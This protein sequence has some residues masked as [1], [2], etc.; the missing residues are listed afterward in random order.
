MR[1]HRARAA[2]ARRRSSRPGP[3][4]TR[5]GRGRR[6]PRRSRGRSRGPARSRGAAPPPRTNGSK[7]RSCS[8]GAMPGPR[9]TTRTSSRPPLTRARTETGSPPE[10]RAA[11]SS[12]FANARSSCAGVGE[13][14]RQVAVDGELH[15]APPGRPADVDRLAQHLLDRAPVAA[16]LGRARLQPRELEQLVD[17]AREPRA[18]GSHAGRELA[19]L[20]VAR[21]RRGERLGRRDDRRQRRAQVV[22]DRA[23]HGGLDLVRAAQRARLDDL[24]RERVARERR[25]RAA[26]RAPGARRRPPRRAAS[27]GRAACR[28][29]RRRA[30]AGA[31]PSARRRRPPRARAGTTAGRRRARS[32]ARPARARRRGR[33][34]RAARGPARPRGRP[35]GPRRTRLRARAPRAPR[36]GSTRPPRRRGRRRSATRFSPSAI[37]KRPV[38]GMWKKLNASALATLVREPEQRAP[39]DRDEQHAEQ[40]DDAERD[41]LRD[42]AE[43]IQQQRLGGDERGRRDQPRQERG[44]PCG[45]QAA[46]HGTE[47]R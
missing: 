7:I 42:L 17:Q 23:Q 11:F 29:A 30:R 47:P 31:P 24:A 38:G 37:V 6:W 16:R 27:W 3:A 41:G 12:R 9:S 5:R 21:G 40:V 35:R 28:G 19:P 25:R 1:R 22:R 45:Q 20:L 18:L 13:D 33:A 43:R 26:P 36:R 44:R 14:Q 2:A 15:A 46:E 34:R 10:W 4:A 8:A 32:A 39:H